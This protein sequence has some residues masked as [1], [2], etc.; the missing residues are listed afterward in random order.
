MHREIW[1]ERERKGSVRES[2]SRRQ[3]SRRIVMLR[4]VTVVE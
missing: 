2:E 3:A 4:P 1:R